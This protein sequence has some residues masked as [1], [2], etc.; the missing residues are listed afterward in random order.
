MQ[1]ETSQPEFMSACWPESRKPTVGR[2][3]LIGPGFWVD[4]IAAGELGG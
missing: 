3:D 1:V 2:I 4:H